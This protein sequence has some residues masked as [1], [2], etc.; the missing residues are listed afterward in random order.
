MAVEILVRCRFPVETS[1]LVLFVNVEMLLS[2]SVCVDNKA[3][4]LA[5]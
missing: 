4:V 1:A 3:F 5:V 2:R